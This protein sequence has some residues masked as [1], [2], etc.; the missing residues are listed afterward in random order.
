MAPALRRRAPGLPLLDARPGDNAARPVVR[1]N[2]RLNGR[3]KIKE[4]KK[5]QTVP[6]RD[7]D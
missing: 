4:K 3:P 7:Y 6:K 1:P 2:V 5:T